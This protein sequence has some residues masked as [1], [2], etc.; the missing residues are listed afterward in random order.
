M[1]N[2]KHVEQLMMLPKRQSNANYDTAYNKMVEQFEFIDNLFKT[3]HC[4]ILNTL[5]NL[6][7]RTYTYV[8][9]AMMLHMSDNALRRNRELYAKGF[10]YC[11]QKIQ[12]NIDVA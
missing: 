3:S 5:Y 6:K 7:D 8:G 2:L 10:M 9:I 1:K 12:T 4:E 11:L